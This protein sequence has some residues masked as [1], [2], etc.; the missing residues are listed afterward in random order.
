[1]SLQKI[2][3]PEFAILFVVLVIILT[4]F[5]LML[6]DIRFFEI[7]VREDGLVEWITVIGLL[8]AAF[9]CFIRVIKLGRHR[10]WLFLLTSVLFG[11]ILF[12]GAGEEISWGQRI[13]G[14]Q[15]P[16]YF[17]E[18]NLQGETN[19]HNLV[20]GGVKINM[21][22]FSFLLITVLGVYLLLM[23]LLYRK[24]K[25]MQDFIRYWGIP[26]PKFYQVIAFVLLFVTEFIP[27]GK[28]A[29]LLEA[30]TALML[31]LII[32][33]PANSQSFETSKK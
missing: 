19:F 9:T 10:N 20:L 18:K 13:L 29:E 11:L 14:I 12:F 33:F 17:K 8:M 3:R 2:S 23:P 15:S 26:L 31:F 4:G 1:M 7:Y 30:G 22:V 6:I 24:K 32:R 28:R 16:E 27:H 5:L 25:W 21:W